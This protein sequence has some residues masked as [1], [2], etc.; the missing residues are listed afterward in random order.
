MRTLVLFLI[1][2]TFGAAGGFVYAAANGITLDGHD[3]ASHGGMDH[4]AMGHGSEDHAAMHD[5]P[6]EVVAADAPALKIMVSKDPMAGYNLH[7]MPTNFKFAPEDASKAHIA[8]EG[9]AHVYA[10]GTKL[11]R[12]YGP[13]MHLDQLPK[14]AVEISVTLNTNDHRPFAV[15]GQPVAASQTITV[16]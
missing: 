15:N 9:H 14:G 6:L 8:G 10:N 4:A 16:D 12:L 2:L 3:H 13:W 11:G 7:V 1:G 5:T